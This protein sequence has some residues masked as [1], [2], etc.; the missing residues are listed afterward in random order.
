MNQEI[1]IEEFASMIKLP[2]EE[3]INYVCNC[4]LLSGWICGY[5]RDNTVKKSYEEW[6]NL[7][8]SCEFG[9]VCDYHKNINASRRLVPITK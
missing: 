7:A 2:V 1:N 9:W 8:C 6:D 4:D 3:V 5:H